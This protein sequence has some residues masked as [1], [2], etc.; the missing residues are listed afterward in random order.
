[1][2]KIKTI[3]EGPDCT[4]EITVTMCCGDSSG[5]CGCRGLPIEPPFCSNECWDAWNKAQDEKR[6]AEKR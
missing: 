2:G 3:C 4:I 5:M 1:M 6:E